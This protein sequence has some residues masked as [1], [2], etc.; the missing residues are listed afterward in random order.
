MTQQHPLLKMFN[1]PEGYIT[2]QNRITDRRRTHLYQGPFDNPGLPM[3]RHGWNNGWNNPYS[4]WRNNI[5]PQGLCKTCMKRAKVNATGVPAT[6]GPEAARMPPDGFSFDKGPI[7]M[8][9]AE[10][11][12]DKGE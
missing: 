10:R 7:S 8:L 1:V 11:A 9:R 2:G 6:I 3:C 4:I 12:L 5:G